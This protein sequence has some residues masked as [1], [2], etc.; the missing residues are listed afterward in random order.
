[1]R[2]PFPYIYQRMVTGTGHSHIS[3]LP[4][5]RCWTHHVN[6]GFENTKLMGPGFAALHGRKRPSEFGYVHE[7]VFLSHPSLEVEDTNAWVRTLIIPWASRNCCR[8]EFYW[9]PVKHFADPSVL[10]S[11]LIN[12]SDLFINIFFNDFILAVSFSMVF[13]ILF[14]AISS[15][16][17]I[18]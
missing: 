8:S 17:F 14:P 1:M 4:F 11:A 13:A 12:P 3:A 6:P 5:S 9:A 10:T 15:F 2:D 16:S 7:Q 18:I